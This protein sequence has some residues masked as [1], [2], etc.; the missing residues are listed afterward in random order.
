MAPRVSPQPQSHRAPAPDPSR[1]W[2]KPALHPPIGVFSTLFP[3]GNN[4]LPL[5]LRVRPFVGG[6]ARGGDLAGKLYFGAKH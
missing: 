1:P 3:P 2:A 5:P 6:E 4:Q